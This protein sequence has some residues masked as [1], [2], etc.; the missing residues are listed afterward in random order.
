MLTA[1]H[2][3]GEAFLLLLVEGYVE[4][5]G[6]IGEFLLVVGPLDLRISVLAHFVEYVELALLLGACVTYRNP[7]IGLLFTHILH[8]ACKSRPVF[9][10]VCGQVQ[11]NL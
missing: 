6:G 11:V 7:A 4:R 1:E 8:G 10:L 5:L 9:L 2:S 3:L